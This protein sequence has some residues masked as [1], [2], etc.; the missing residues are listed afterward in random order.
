MV[1]TPVGR[2]FEVFDRQGD[3]PT[4]EKIQQGVNVSGPCCSAQP[5][6]QIITIVDR[7]GAV[8]DEPSIVGRPGDA[9]DRGPGT[10]GELNR[11]RTDTAGRTRDRYR[12]SGCEAHRPHRGIGGDPRHKQRAGYLPRHRSRPRCQLV[13]R[14]GH[15]LCVAGAPHGEPDHLVADSETLTP[16]P[17]SATT[18]ARSLP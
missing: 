1:S 13:R 15:I 3:I 2:E 5:G 12:I 8:V 9:E 4:T 18:P 10:S 7:D 17:S 16:G 6:R 11:D 14:H